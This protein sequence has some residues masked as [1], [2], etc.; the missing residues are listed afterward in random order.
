MRDSGTESAA[1][2]GALYR[3]TLQAAGNKYPGFLIA[4]RGFAPISV[5]TDSNALAFIPLESAL[6]SRAPQPTMASA[7][8]FGKPELSTLLESG[9]FYFALTGTCGRFFTLEDRS[10]YSAAAQPRR[11]TYLRS[12]V[13]CISRP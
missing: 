1:A 8:G 7:I 11:S 10:T 13:S 4:T 3:E 9:T 6:L 2:K 12:S 5:Q